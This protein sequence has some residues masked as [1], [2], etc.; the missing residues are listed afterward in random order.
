MPGLATEAL[1]LRADGAWLV[2]RRGPQCRDE[3]GLLEGFGGGVDSDRDLEREMTRELVEELG[4]KV[5]F[6]LLDRLPEKSILAGTPPTAWRVFPFVVRFHGGEPE[7]EPGKNDGFVWLPESEWSQGDVAS[8]HQGEL[9][10][11]AQ[12]SALA[13]RDWCAGTQTGYIANREPGETR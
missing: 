7:P 12:L 8:I 10:S 13:L 11:S 9:S 1:V 2:H 3:I 5:E 6:E 4:P